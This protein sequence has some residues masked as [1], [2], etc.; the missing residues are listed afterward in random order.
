MGMLNLK[1]IWQ[2]GNIKISINNSS[3][4]CCEYHVKMGSLFFSD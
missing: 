4:M 1:S 3:K 2:T